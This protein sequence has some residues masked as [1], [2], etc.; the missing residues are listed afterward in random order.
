MI[1]WW[2]CNCVS[3]R[4]SPPK[5]KHQWHH[6][7]HAGS[8]AKLHIISQYK[9]RNFIETLFPV[10]L[11][12]TCSKSQKKKKKMIEQRIANGKLMMITLTCVH[13]H[14]IQ[15]PYVPSKQVFQPWL[16]V[17]G[18]PLTP[19]PKQCSLV[20][21]P[22]THCNRDVYVLSTVHV[23][24]WP[25]H[26]SIL[27]I[28]SSLRACLCRRSSK[29]L[30]SSIMNALDCWHGNQGVRTA[31]I[32]NVGTGIRH[33]AGLYTEISPRGG[34]FGVWTKEGGRAGW[35]L[36]GIMWGATL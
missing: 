18:P 25:C 5:L 1:L 27:F 28:S 26:T 12:F 17:A 31:L 7:S 19:T 22:Q 2:Y 3:C 33:M 8:S 9:Q 20:E 35:K 4:S 23:T 15:Q 34:E 13:T 11:C 16:P 30:T 32:L 6:F 36:S 21:P 24:W 10:M 14:E 29:F